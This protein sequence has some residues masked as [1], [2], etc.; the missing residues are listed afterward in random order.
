MAAETGRRP[1]T[2][3]TSPRALP[4]PPPQAVMGLLNYLTATSLD[5]DYAHVSARRRAAERRAAR[6]RT[7]GERTEGESAG[8]RSPGAWGLVVLAVFGVLVATAAVQTSRNSE[9]TASSRDAL[10]AQANDRKAVLAGQQDRVVAL[11]RSIAAVRS[12]LLDT[13]NQASATRTR[14]RTLGVATG[15]DSARGPGVR[16]TVDD[17]P[18]AASTKQKVIGQDLQRLANG[19]WQV[20][21]EAVSINGQRLTSLS[22]IRDAGK[23]ITVNKVSLRRPYVLSAIGGPQMGGALLETSGGQTW[24]ALQSSFG[25]KFDV[26][27]EESMTLPPAQ[28]L[29]VRHA[30]QPRSSQERQQ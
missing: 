14:L 17:A 30:R 2:P 25:L 6:E 12:D 15:E 21:A 19:L 4:E 5:E 8:R 3:P 18:D 16:V 11:E 26:T 20:G 9:E 27:T 23:A 24:A 13:T 10:V 29:V 28:G 1:E 22:A 7:E